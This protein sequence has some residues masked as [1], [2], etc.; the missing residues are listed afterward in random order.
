M[1]TTQELVDGIE[2]I[3]RGW[4]AVM[5]RQSHFHLSPCTACGGPSFQEPCPNCNF[6]MDYNRPQEGRNVPASTRDDFIAQVEKAGNLACWYYRS[7]KRTVA[8]SRNIEYR[9][10]LDALLGDARSWNGLPDAGEVWDKVSGERV[11]LSREQDHGIYTVWQVL[12]E[13]DQA[14]EIG[15]QL[16]HSPYALERGR[17]LCA[18]VKETAITAIHETPAPDTRKAM[19]ALQPAVYAFLDL[20]V[21][22]KGNLIMVRDNL[23]RAMEASMAVAGTEQPF[24]AGLRG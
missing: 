13:L 18:E 5:G 14:L 10:K 19:E 23:S 3:A 21:G 11:S 1:A 22:V 15:A 16:G 20:N 8:Y 7:G 9:T 4:E 17:K 24:K 6:Y 2:S 12:F